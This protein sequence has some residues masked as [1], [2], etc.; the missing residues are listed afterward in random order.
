MK[1]KIVTKR[2]KP[3]TTFSTE[4]EYWLYYAK[5]AFTYKA[6]DLHC[7]KQHFQEILNK[8]AKNIMAQSMLNRCFEEEKLWLLAKEEQDKK[9][10]LLLLTKEQSTSS[11]KPRK[12]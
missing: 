4:E 9:A 10:D 5:R 12:Q 3:K 7:W 11:K 1:K 6:L 2:I 8:D